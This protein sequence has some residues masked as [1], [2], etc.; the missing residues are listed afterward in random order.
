MRRRH[1]AVN[2]WPKRGWKGWVTRKT[3]LSPWSLSVVWCAVYRRDAPITEE[4]AQL[5]REY[6]D[7]QPS[8]YPYVFVPPKRYDRIQRS[9]R[10]GKW[11]ERQGNCPHGNFQRQFTMILEKAGIKEGHFHDLRRTCLSNWFSNGLR[12]YEV[13]KIAGHASFE[14]TH[15]FY[16]SIRQDLLDHARD[17]SSVAMKSFFIA[18]T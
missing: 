14:T 10:L 12:E 4:L 8:G 3:L 11:S 7:Q 15:K 9:R 6:R 17:L 2:S 16:L 1:N 5:L 13:M 18:K